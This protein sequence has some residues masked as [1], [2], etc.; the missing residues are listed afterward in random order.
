MIK[1]RRLRWAD[2]VARI[3]EGR[4]VLKILAGTYTGKRPLGSSRHRWED[5][6]TIDLKEIGV[7]ARNW[8]GSAEVRNY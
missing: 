5:N 6:I 2:H 4:S 8:V 7:N 1:S 3:G